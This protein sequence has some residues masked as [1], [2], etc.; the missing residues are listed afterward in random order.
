MFPKGTTAPMKSIDSKLGK[1]TR[2]EPVA[3]RLE[4]GRLHM[5]GRHPELETQC[6]E[7]VPDSGGDS[8]DRMDAMVHVCR[9]FMAAEKR[10][11]KISSPQA[12]LAAAARAVDIASTGNIDEMRIPDD[13]SYR[14]GG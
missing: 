12:A 1:R 3:M 8:P 4:Q 6:A 10:T 11:M 9:H 2:A 5:V 14:Y 7:F 13:W